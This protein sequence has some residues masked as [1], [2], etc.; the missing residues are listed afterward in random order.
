[1][2]VLI[3]DI[4]VRKRLRKEMGDIDALAES[5]KRFGQITPIVINNKSVLLAGGRRLE[6]ARQLGW[7]TINAVVADVSDRAAALEYEME[8]NIQRSDF[9]REEIS[10]AIRKIS[11]Y[12]NPGFFMRIWLAVVGLFKRIFRV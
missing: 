9:T 2:Q 3:E 12:R 10:E 6:A 5:L 11:K 1:M 7:R 8:E 4:I